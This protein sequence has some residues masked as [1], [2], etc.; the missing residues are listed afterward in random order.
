MGERSL[1]TNVQNLRNIRCAWRC[2]GVIFACRCFGQHGM[3]DTRI[4]GFVRGSRARIN[5]SCRERYA[6]REIASNIPGQC[7]DESI[8]TINWARKMSRHITSAAINSVRLAG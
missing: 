2:H 3:K 4:N 1:R 5:R 8:C 6:T 7:A